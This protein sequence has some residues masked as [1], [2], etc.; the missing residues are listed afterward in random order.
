MIERRSFLRFAAALL[1]PAAFPVAAQQQASLP[2]IGIVA[3]TNANAEALVAALRERGY[4]DGSTV[5]I[6]R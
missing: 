3:R 5:V 1:S 6:E 2:R 4:V